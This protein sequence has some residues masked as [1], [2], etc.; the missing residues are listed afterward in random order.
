MAS[1]DDVRRIALS[2]PEATEDAHRFGFSVAG[3]GFAWAWN[4]RI[5]PNRARVPN[6]DVIALRIV[7]ESEKD[8]LIDMNPDV[9]FTEP[10][11]DGYCAILAR[12]PAIDVGLLEI[13]LRDAWR[14]RAPRRLLERADREVSG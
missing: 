4:E 9:F 14:E 7:H 12:L 2:L 10:H 6:P 3:K 13:M 5:Q 8:A 11:Y 1:Q